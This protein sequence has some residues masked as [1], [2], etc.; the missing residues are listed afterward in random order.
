MT[1]LRTPAERDADPTSRKEWEL[2]GSGKMTP[3]QRRMLNAVCGCLAAQLSWHGNRLS[4][5]DW[6]HMLAGTML[7]WRMMPAIDRGEGAAGFIMLGGSSLD[8]SKTLACN[9]ITCG[10][11]IGDHPEEQKLR[12]KP[13]QWS[14]AVLR[15]LGFNDSDI[16]RLRAA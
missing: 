5:D 2:D 14:Y 6:R 10:L 8:L 3:K 11:H 1:T 16:Q 7:G 12:C 9:A 15:G 4:L 13:V